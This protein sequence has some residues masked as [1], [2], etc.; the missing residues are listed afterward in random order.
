M[1]II[2]VV[3][4]VLC[5]NVN[6]ANAA[7]FQL[8]KTANNL[9]KKALIIK[10]DAQLYHSATSENGSPAPFIQLYFLMTP[11]QNQRV[12]VLKT[13]S[14]D[15]T[16]PDGWLEKSAYV[17]WNTVQMIHFE[18]QAGR[19]RVKIYATSDCAAE[20]GST[21]KTADQC[22]VIGQEPA[23]N[24]ETRLFIPLF[25]QQAG[26]YH[27]GFI[28]IYRENEENPPIQN[29]SPKLGYDLV[30]V[31]DSTLSM[32]QYFQPTMRVLQSFIQIVQDTMQ[33]EVAKPLNI[34][35]L[36]YRDRNLLQ[37][38]DIGY[39]TH[40]AQPL[41]ADT[42]KVIAA[43][44][45]AEPTHCDSEDIPEAV[46][47]GVYRALIDTSWNNSHFKTIVL[48][49][50]APPNFDKNPM[51]LNVPVVHELADKKSVRFLTF[52]IGPTD[53][54]A[55]EEFEALAL[56]RESRLKGRFTRVTEA[57]ID[58]FETNLMDALIIEWDMF[59]KTLELSQS[60]RD[61]SSEQPGSMVTSGPSNMTE[62]ELPI[63]I[64]QLE[65][66][67]QSEGR[68]FV[69]GWVS[70]K[71]KNR[72]A[73]GEYIF[74]RKVDLKLR[75]LI[76]ESIL[77]AAEA[78]IVDGA[79]AF[80][81]AVRETLA[82]HLKMKTTDIFS[83]NETLA[84]ILE[85]ANILPFKTELLLFTPDEINTWKPVDYERLNQTLTEKIRYLRQF[86]NNPNHIRLF[87]GIPYLYIP[88]GYFP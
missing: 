21:G 49:G 27:G 84:E 45:T 54:Q 72:L 15:K 22:Q 40:W 34:G 6:L 3:I 57:N 4:I 78:G 18:S 7:E 46:F 58:Q 20:F 31:V 53:D 66:L 76:L 68:D 36:F 52:K 13:F 11:S 65:K 70:R 64:G 79:D 48:I 60:D 25:E 33:G 8:D 38:C 50:D 69:K 51:N 47:D 26:T 23:Q 83:G 32:A 12:P 71:V 44:N 16:V 56:Q 61:T 80:L 55:Y 87:E 39:L 85:K 19:E 81:S 41:T 17:E 1:F 28:R 63:I 5:M 10:H 88:K 86:S 37:K 30:L 2:T 35:L 74:I 73:F 77:T 59:N 67:E 9:P 29:E 24:P 82:I 42:E 14:K 75:L 62:Y 43:L